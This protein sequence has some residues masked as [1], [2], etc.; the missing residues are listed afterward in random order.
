MGK[1][2]ITHFSIHQSSKVIAVVYFILGL[3]VFALAALQLFV[4]GDLSGA[5]GV[6]TYLGI[7]F[8]A[9]IAYMIIGYIVS[10]ISFLLYNL[11]AKSFG[12]VEFTLVDKE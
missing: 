3:I 7:V 9:A 11:I 12:G 4:T 8:L 6:L 10:A 1:K 5:T 2:Q